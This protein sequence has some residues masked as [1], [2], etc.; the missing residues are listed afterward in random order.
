M[1]HNLS[2]VVTWLK[3]PSPLSNRFNPKRPHPPAGLLDFGPRPSADAAGQP[4]K[5][6]AASP[7]L[8]VNQFFKLGGD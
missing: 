4:Q 1:N 2:N 7:R 3:H 8:G 5:G 6:R